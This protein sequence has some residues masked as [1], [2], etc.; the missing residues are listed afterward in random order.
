MA[1][2]EFG[3][4]DAGRVVICVHGLTRNGRDFDTLATALAEAGCRVICPDVVGRGESSW[5]SDPAGYGFPQYLADM[6]VLLA[7]LE[8]EAV[9]WV[10]TSKGGLIGMTLATQSGTPQSGTPQSGTPQSGT[11]QSGTPQSGT[12]Q[13]GTPQSGTP[14]S[15][16]PQSGTPQSGTPQSGTPQSGTPQSGTP[17]SG[18]P[19]SGTPQSG[20]PQSGT[21]QSGTPQSGTPQSGTPQSGTPQSGTPQSGTPQSGTPQSGTP[22]S[23]TPQSGTPQS[24]TP[25]SGT[26]Q[27]GTPQSGTPQSGTPQSGTP[28]SGTPQFGTPQSGT[29][30]RRLVLNDVGPFLPRAALARIGTY[31]GHDPR[32]ADLEA[33][34]AYMRDVH[35]GFGALADHEWRYLTEISVAAAKGGGEGALRLR[36]DPGIGAAFH[37]APPK[38]VDLWAVWDRLTAP[39][40]VLRGADSDLLLPETAAEMTRRGPRTELTEIAGCGHAPALMD[41]A[42]VARVRDWLLA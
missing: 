38:D 14:Q 36:Y 26:P 29:P 21:P 10:G 2:R 15:G 16:T 1:Y 18:T 8:T 5:L 30:L 35:A 17:Q 27:S 4:P 11:P 31:V 25:Q 42:Q 40:L 19:Q 7:R 20:T 28:Q 32:F 22:Q 34:E 23:G 9:D 37:V 12:P 39:T 13:S 41:P 24:G 33:A 6:T 3:A